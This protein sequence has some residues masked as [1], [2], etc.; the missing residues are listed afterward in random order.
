MESIEKKN[1]V[2]LCMKNIQYDYLEKK[3]TQKY[4]M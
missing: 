4:S 2:L 1:M 3:N